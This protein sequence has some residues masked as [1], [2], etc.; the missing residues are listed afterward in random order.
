MV[1]IATDLIGCDPCQSQFLNLP[2]D[3]GCYI[4]QT[5]VVPGLPSFPPLKKN[6]SPAVRRGAGTVL[7]EPLFGIEPITPCTN[8]CRFNWSAS[9][10]VVPFGTMTLPA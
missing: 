7:Y 2:Q 4:G 6:G 5:S 3:L 8:H 9:D 10:M 1:G